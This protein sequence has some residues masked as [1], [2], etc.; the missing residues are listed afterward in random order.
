MV[1][2]ASVRQTNNLV[3][4][5]AGATARAAGGAAMKAKQNIEALAEKIVGKVD[6]IYEVV[7][8]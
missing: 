1:K 6:E 2:S 5:L 3:Q 7:V 4:L 8:D